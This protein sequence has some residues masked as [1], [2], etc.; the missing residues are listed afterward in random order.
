MSVQAST[1]VWKWQELSPG[2][3]LVALCL[4]DHANHQG[5]NAFPSLDTIATF[6]AM[7]RRGVQKA[8]DRLIDG[9]YL[10]LQ[11]EHTNRKSAV[12]RVVMAKV[13][14]PPVEALEANT[15]PLCGDEHSSPQE[16]PEVNPVHPRGEL[17]APL[18]ANPVHPIRP[19]TVRDPHTTRA[20]GPN[21]IKPHPLDEPEP[22][23]AVDSVRAFDALAEI[24]PR[25]DYRVL[26]LRAWQALNPSPALAAVIHAAVA[27]RLSAGWGRDQA[28]HFLPKLARF[29]EERHWQERYVP[30]VGA[31]PPS[32]PA[33]TIRDGTVTHRACPRC[34]NPQRGEYRG[35]RQV[36]D[37]ACS[38]CT[39]TPKAVSA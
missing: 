4:A 35:G 12:Y 33:D 7:S 36:F 2:E 14:A 18:E 1:V 38:D 25:K 19:T 32:K 28:L 23:L 3:K 27:A 39:A 11:A 5:A 31:E 13:D 24:Y 21:G 29:L 22:L 30:R 37:V 6:T 15:V 17:S 9:G 34:G 16:P 10:E 20:R 8:L 26:A